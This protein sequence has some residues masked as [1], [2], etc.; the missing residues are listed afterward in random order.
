MQDPSS[1]PSTDCPRESVLG[2]PKVPPGIALVVPGTKCLSSS[3]SLV[4][5]VIHHVSSS[6]PGPLSIEWEA[7]SLFASNLCSLPGIKAVQL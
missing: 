5:T 1:I 3:V 4:L 2:G 6:V 7:P